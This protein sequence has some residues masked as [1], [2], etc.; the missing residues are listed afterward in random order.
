MRVIIIIMVIT[1]IGWGS[2]V[3]KRGS[4]GDVMYICY[5]TSIFKKFWNYIL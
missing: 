4:L 2:R 1:R 5:F 3:I